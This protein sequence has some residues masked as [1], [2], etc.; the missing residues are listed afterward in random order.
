MAGTTTNTSALLAPEQVGDLIVG[1]VIEQSIA[2]AVSTVVQTSTHTF[3]VP[4]VTADP[5]AAWVNEG[6][7]IT[8]S[9]LTV[10]EVTTTPA[11]V[12]GLTIITRELAA[13]SSPAAAQQVG[14]GLVRDIIRVVDSGFFGDA[15][16]PGPAGLETLTGVTDVYAGASWANLDPFAAALAGAEQV[17]ARITSWVANPADALALATIKAS[18]GSNVP[19]LGNDVT[20]P[21]GRTIA[22]VQLHVS[23]AV[24]AGTI[25]GIPQDRAIVVIRESTTVET[26][27]SVYFTSDRV[28]VKATMRVGY[29]FPH[30]AAIIKVQLGTAP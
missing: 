14:D 18:D 1:P 11:K 8:P 23:P 12:A 7:E 25:W 3:R 20:V 17:G 16:A 21:S 15:P 24:T 9:D 5:T 26:D 22:G 4:L 28:A 10:A 2:T 30:P 19:L 29:L 13:D 27:S 6:Q